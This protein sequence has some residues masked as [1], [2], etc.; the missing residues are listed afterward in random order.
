MTLKGRA[1]IITG[2]NQGLGEAIAAEF[3]RQGA[4]VFICA[5]DKRKLSLAHEKLK[6]LGAK[7]QK[8]GCMVAD[9]SKEGDVKKLIK[10]AGA[11]FKRI[12]ILVNNAGIYGP[13]GPLE[14][15]NSSDWLKAIQINLLGVFYCCKHVLPV[16][17][18]NRYG[19]IIN[20]SGG[21]ATTPFPFFSAYAAA[22]AGVVRLTETL[23]E[24]CKGFHIDVNSLAPGALNT[25]L[26]EEALA[27]GPQVVG[28][29]F[30][31]KSLQQKQTGGA[32]LKRAAALCAFLASS[33]SDG[34]TGRLMSAVWDPWEKL[35]EH[36]EAL[37]KTDIYTLR[38]IT[39]KDRNQSWGEE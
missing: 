5:R 4:D 10:T 6:N 26:L 28:K 21:G 25:R 24:E 39:P 37:Q 27:A 30:Y 2:A 36:F 7:S 8:T 38:R 33:S 34:L 32:S 13:K 17:K 22:K 35:T 23:A 20:L 11:K 15:M 29:E 14:T 31:A 1:A 3:V 9:I 16:M 18:K 19:K 12:D